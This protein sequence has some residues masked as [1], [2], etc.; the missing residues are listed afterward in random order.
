MALTPSK[1]QPIVCIG[2]NGKP[3]AD[4]ISIAA[5]PSFVQAPLNQVDPR[6]YE[7]HLYDCASDKGCFTPDGKPRWQGRDSSGKLVWNHSVQ[8]CDDKRNCGKWALRPNPPRPVT[9]YFVAF[10]QQK[11]AYGGQRV[12]GARLLQVPWTY[13]GQ[14]CPNQP[15]PPGLPEG[16][17]TR[18]QFGWMGININGQLT[19]PDPADLT[20]NF[21]NW[22]F[23]GHDNRTGANVRC[24]GVLRSGESVRPGANGVMGCVAQWG[25][26]DWRCQGNAQM[27]VQWTA[28]PGDF[29]WWATGACVGT[30]TEGGKPPE[31]NYNFGVVWLK[32]G[33]G[34]PLK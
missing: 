12:T 27:D 7:F 2:P 3:L 9:V 4:A 24:A 25:Q 28:I 10:V 19:P 11:A 31:Q 32:S 6:Q 29:G 22:Q 5:N 33:L 13:T 17:D 20:G 21:Q 1:P 34:L 16:Q 26:N 8:Q 23:T 14:R 15:L 30:K 18:V